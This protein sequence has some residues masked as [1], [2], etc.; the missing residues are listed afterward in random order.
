M[1]AEN[2]VD[3]EEAEMIIKEA[4]DDYVDIETLQ[5]IIDMIYGDEFIV[6]EELDQE[7]DDGFSDYDDYH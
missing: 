4:I 2:V 6:V 3:R 7:T 1:M 5:Q